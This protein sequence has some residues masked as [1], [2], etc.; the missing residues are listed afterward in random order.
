[1][2]KKH[3]KL[4]IE[5]DKQ[6]ETNQWYTDVINKSNLIEYTKVSGC[7]VLRPRSQFMWDR[8]RDY[9]D[10][11]I[12]EKGVKNT[13]FPLLIPESNLTKEED[14]VEGFAPEVAWVTHGG[15]SKLAERLAIRPTSETIMYP[16]FSKWVR[17]YTDLPL[18]INQWCSVVRWE[19]KNP[20]PFLRGREFHWQ[21][22]HTA[23]A[24]RKDADEEAMDILINL[25]KKT[26][27]DILAVPTLVG[28]KSDKEKFAGAEYSL[29]CE[30][31]L[32]IGKAIQGCT[33]HHLGQGFAKA[34]DISFQDQN[35][36]TQLVHQ[37]S[38]GLSTRVIG[39][40]IMMHSDNKGLVIPPRLAENKVIIVPIL[41]KGDNT[42]LI[43]FTNK[44]K[45]DLKEF[46]AVAD[47]R[48]GISPG[49][50]FSEAE[51]HGY[52][53][54]VEVGMRELEEGNLT[55]VR[56]DTLEKVTVSIDDVKSNIPTM[57]DDIHNNLYAKAND[58]LKSSIVEE[59]SDLDKISECVKEGKI[60]KTYF[61]NNAATDELIKDLTTGKTL[62]IPFDETLPE[63]AI[64][65]FTKEPA[66]DIVYVARSL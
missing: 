27:D 3:N 36:E 8:I 60:V 14:H 5:F 22:G 17:S 15:S 18:K 48:E 6:T 57:L 9:M 29:S 26:Y 16:A 39:V 4:G 63:G 33:S 54:R 34:F 51:L 45:L 53:I 56:R 66:T 11:I 31:F 21:E 1:M 61:K 25:Y 52:P 7:Y 20:T 10:K 42:E 30:A 2:A 38:W 12:R 50:K 43:E 49:F 47:L 32:P 58:F 24:T 37:N 65:P 44:L 19:F 28:K 46:D 55:L 41:K 62:N 35:Q 64:C 23:F 40:I 13:S 59:Y